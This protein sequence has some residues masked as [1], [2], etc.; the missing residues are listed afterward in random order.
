MTG[1]TALV[2]NIKTRQLGC[3]LIQAAAGGDMLTFHRYF[4]AGDWT[5]RWDEN[6]RVVWGTDKEW[7]AF[8]A[9]YGVL[10][11]LKRKGSIC[12]KRSASSSM[13]TRESRRKRLATAR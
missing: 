7:K 10:G 4:E 6:M 12:T 1:K 8:A 13:R 9:K 3:A 5:T 11:R 2:M